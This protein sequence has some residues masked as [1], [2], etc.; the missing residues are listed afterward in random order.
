MKKILALFT[1]PSLALATEAWD[2]KRLMSDFYA[3]GAAIGDINGDSKPD[4]AYGPFWFAGPDFATQQRFAEGEAFSPLVYSDNFFSYI[5]DVTGDGL[6]DI[7]VFGF[8]GKA[9]RLY[10]NPGADKLDSNW[11]MHVIA[12]QLCHEAPSMVDLIPGGLPEL[13]GSRDTQYGY[14]AAGEDPTQAWVWHPVSAE[15]KAAKPFGHGM[16]VGDVNGDGRL[17][18]IER[19]VWYEQ[20]E[21][22]G[23]GAW[24][25][26]RWAVVP[27]G[28]GGAQIL[29]DD[30]DG[31]GD[32][33][34]ITSLNAHGY[35]IAWF[36]Q[37]EPGRFARHNVIDDSS[38]KNPYGVSFSQPHGMELADIDGDGRN[39]FVTGKR[40]MAHRGHDP[41]AFQ[42]PVVYWFRNVKTADGVEFVPHLIDNDSG[43]GVGVQVADL[44]GDGALDIVSAN[45]RGLAVHWQKKDVIAEA[46]ELWKVSGGRPQE[47]YGSGL[48]PEESLKRFDLP[49]G[50]AID[51]IAAEPDLTQPI[52]MCFDARGRIWVVEGHTYPQRAPEGEG[53][54]RVVIFEDSDG[55]GSFETKKT[56][57][58]GINLA[59][60]IEVG[61]GGVYVGAAP[62]LLFYPDADSDD[63]PD[64]EPEILLDG[65]AWQDTHET[66]N[67]FTWGPDG[68]L[69]GCH[70]VFTHSNVGKPGCR[71]EER[72][73]IN[74]GVWRFHPVKKEFE[75][76]A[77]GS[78]N[79]WGVDFDEHGDWFITACVIPHL[80]HLS[81]GG[82]YFRQAGQHFNPYIFDDIKTIADHVHYG[83]GTFASM[84]ERG[85]VDR[86]LSAR[87]ASDTSAVGGG[88]AHCGLT[89]Y[90]ADA[91]PPPYQ[92][93]LFFSNLHGH[94]IIR[95]RVEHEGSG[96]VGRHLPD[97]AM[98]NDHEFIGVGVMQGPDGALYVSD[99]HDSQT[100][101]HRDVEIWDRSNG[102]LYR[103]RHG[104]VVSTVTELPDKTDDELVATLAHSN[105]FHARQAQRLL[106]ERVAAKTADVDG[107]GT[108]LSKFEKD[109]ADSV[110]LRLRALWTRHVCGLMTPETAVDRLDDPSEYIRAWT[111]QLLGEM[112]EALPGDMLT[113]FETMAVEDS[114]RVVRRYLASKLQRLPLDQRWG[115]AEGLISHANDQYDRNIPLLCWYGIEPLVGVDGPRALVLAEKTE[116]PQLREFIAR[117]AA[118]TPEGRAGLMKALASVENAEGFVQRAGQL[119][120]ALNQLP[121]VGSPEG[122]EQA[123][124]NGEQL[125]GEDPAVADVIRRM[126]VRF[127]DADFLPHWR[128]VAR[129]GKAKPA[130]RIQAIE[131]LQAGRDPKLGE[132]ARELIDQR[133][134]LNAVVTALRTDPGAAT[135]EVLVARLADFPLQLRNEAIN[136]LATRPEMALVLLKAVDEKKLAASLI[137]PVMLDQ[138][139]RFK[140]DDITAIIERNWTRGGGDVDL[141]QLAGAIRQWKGK[142]SDKVLAKADAS[143]G[144]QIFTM[145]CGTCHTL[146]GQGIALGPDLTGSNR[147]DLNYLLENVLAPSA[148]VGK[149]YLLNVFTLKDGSVISGMLRG[150]SPDYFEVVMP[151]GTTADVKKS[152]VETRQELAQSLMPVGMF[153]ALPLEQVADLVK[154]LGSPAQVPMPGQ[155]QPTAASGSV[156]PPAEGVTRF[157]GEALVATAKATGGNARPQGMERF[158]GGAWSGDSQLWWTGGKPGDTLTLNLPEVKP[159][160]RE[161]T[162]F[163]TTAKDYAQMKVTVNGEIQEADLFTS[164]VLPG[165]PIV[166]SKVP[167]SPTEPL[168]I[169]FEITGANPEA[170][171][172]HMVGID[173]IE[174]K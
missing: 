79:P 101:H 77:E 71:D 64:G 143:R 140:N 137:S 35:G 72:Q 136:L 70:G 61:F 87:L 100:C 48:S 122:W 174:V 57:V 88:H 24:K 164:D 97:F 134:L 11:T 19:M 166:F 47:G 81:Q 141:N 127:G 69:Y 110:P 139:E 6:N 105:V 132:L 170:K 129:N 52:A 169:T 13:V 135:A 98:A 126:G 84:N 28:G 165:T 49:E 80:Y 93:N 29:V 114:S 36:E 82:R 151:G 73:P 147:A 68:W 107:I 58:E 32:N 5:H 86:G 9:V 30:V 27:Y 20:P 34:L 160:E 10:V 85:G 103:I 171:P 99:W 12:D 150:D 156:P 1:L 108:A 173:R 148:V 33:D 167:V 95:E 146:F 41:A 118:I 44:N 31:D 112:K 120:T 14:Y 25:E 106:Q 18:I 158:T 162:V 138:F 40:W 17:D 131:L 75:V 128:S 37:T 50:F 130:E 76:F 60:G 113:K 43:V 65:W 21:K 51:L 39:D 4:I 45:K 154:Y 149:D 94:R 59:S 152:D 116:W 83:D 53:K 161:L 56:F 157:E 38:I 159:G 2:S 67:A 117:R 145:I 104:E 109:H 23:D 55:D 102:R 153:D 123:R 66:L 91:F 124:A 63:K 74:A 168:K 155:G 115:L 7:V 15:G 22:A 8:P 121:P 16:G 96:F 163:T 78:S 92:G 144:R 142:L 119:L 42:E 46:A 3:E 111:V 62:H 172:S 54:D 90:Q 26:N 125:G 133:V 89:I